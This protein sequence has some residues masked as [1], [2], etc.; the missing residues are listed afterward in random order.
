M[1]Q[2]TPRCRATQHFAGC[3]TDFAFSLISPAWHF[4]LAGLAAVSTWIFMLVLL[5][6]LKP[7]K[8]HT[9]VDLPLDAGQNGWASSFLFHFHRITK[10]LRRI[11]IGLHLLSGWPFAAAWLDFCATCFRFCTAP[12]LSSS[13]RFPRFHRSRGVFADEVAS[14]RLAR[15]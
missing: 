7:D 15:R 11:S 2:S 4:A 6:L 12:L 1:K 9:V 13:R 14:R 10:F 3:Q 8:M 5:R